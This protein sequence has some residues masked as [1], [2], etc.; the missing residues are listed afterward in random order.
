MQLRIAT[1]KSPLALWQAN[2]VAEQLGA[3]RPDLEVMLVSQDTSADKDLSKPIS[4]IG[5]KGVFAKEIQQLVLGGMADIA[6]H[7]A[8]DLQAET[9]EGLFLG[10]FCVR[11]DARDCLVGSTLDDLAEGA[12]VGTGSARRRVQLL[13]ARPDLN[14]VGLRGNIA[15]RLSRASEMDAIVMAAVALERL[16]I[17]PGVIDLLSPDQMV[18]QVGQGAL[19][20]ECLQNNDSVRQL[21][22][23]IDHE[24][25]RAVVEAE[26]DFLKTLGG[27]CDLPAGAHAQLGIDGLLVVTGVLADEHDRLVRRSVTSAESD[28]PGRDVAMT[29]RD[30]IE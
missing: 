11:G 3:V 22:A 5:G 15:T 23:E 2:Y 13:H 27:D 4:E 30:E 6:V 14:V 25:T 28:R 29:L 10:A 17:D 9:P 26:R 19:A 1:R 7:S 21:L 20:I 12:T 24:K 18:P 16:D 8:K